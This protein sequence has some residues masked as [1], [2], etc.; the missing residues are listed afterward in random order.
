MPELLTVLSCAVG[1]WCSQGRIRPPAHPGGPFLQTYQARPPQ[2]AGRNKRSAWRRCQFCGGNARRSAWL[3]APYE[4]AIADE[5]MDSAAVCGGLLRPVLGLEVGLR[6]W[7]CGETRNARAP[8]KR[9][10][11]VMTRRDDAGRLIG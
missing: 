7:H 6:S 1:L 8:N 5:V 10:S 3:I 4:L 11:P 9:R 2:S